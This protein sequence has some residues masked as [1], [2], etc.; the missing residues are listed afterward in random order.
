VPKTRVTPDDLKQAVLV[1]IRSFGPCDTLQD[2]VIVRVHRATAAAN[3]EIDGFIGDGAAP[4]S[5]DCKV[6]AFAMQILLQREFEVIWQED[7]H[8]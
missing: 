4:V 7:D 3:W 1:A 5:H 2:I 8:S 6:H